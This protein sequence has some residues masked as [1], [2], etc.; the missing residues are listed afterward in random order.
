[1]KSS[2][3]FFAAVTSDVLVVMAVSA[4]AM[5][6]VTF[7]GSA[8]SAQDAAEETDFG[9]WFISAPIADI[10]DSGEMTATAKIAVNACPGK[11]VICIGAAS[12]DREDSDRN[13]EYAA[14][15]RTQCVTAVRTNGGSPVSLPFLP[16]GVGSQE[17]RGILMICA[18]SSS[19]AE[20]SINVTD[21]TTAQCPS[22]GKVLTVFNGKV[23]KGEYPICN[24][25]AGEGSGKPIGDWG[26]GLQ[27]AW[28]GSSGVNLGSLEAVFN[29]H[30]RMNYDWL[31]W[32]FQ[33]GPGVGWING[34]SNVV[35]TEF[36]GIEFRPK[37][38]LSIDV[39]ARHRV[40]FEVKDGDAFNAV[41]AE[42]AFN[43]L[44]K[45]HWCVSVSGAIGNVW[46]VE[47]TQETGTFAAG[48]TPEIY[49]ELKNEVGGSV[50]FSLSYKF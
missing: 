24:G 19:G 3:R 42:V 18:G 37:D 43:F 16:E 15:R 11:R 13:S 48:Y 12:G 36:A 41:M 45:K 22:G 2:K 20:S 21:A 8:A 1:M 5:T 34:E 33:V 32:K 26:L 30:L 4:V 23:K 7:S 29:V 31:F 47:E 9:P 25:L 10:A 46:Y 44:I 17:G 14:N 39:G 6:V 28:S 27:G 49:R 38:W 35:L 40:A 50:T